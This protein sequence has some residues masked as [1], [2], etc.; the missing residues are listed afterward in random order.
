V[1]LIIT[2]VK[3]RKDDIWLQQAFI[4][5]QTSHRKPEVN[6]G[7]IC[8]FDKRVSHVETR[9]PKI[10]ENR[11]Q[12][13]LC[14]SRTRP[15]HTS[16][17]V[18]SSLSH[19]TSLVITTSKPNRQ[20][21]WVRKNISLFFV[22]IN[23]HPSH[24]NLQLLSFLPLLC[25]LA[26]PVS[27]LLHLIYIRTQEQAMSRRRSR[28]LVGCIQWTGSTGSILRQV[29]HCSPASVSASSS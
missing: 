8:F 5:D 27:T 19:W 15:T 21:K 24:Q 18:I 10:P 29:L 25:A 9:E 1:L 23:S 12:P 28:E 22:Q 11:K 2:S 6:T 20:I 4:Q 13:E 16:L 14:T 3:V 17:W 26:A 7:S